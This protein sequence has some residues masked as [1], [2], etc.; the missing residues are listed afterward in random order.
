MSEDFTICDP[1]ENEYVRV[2]FAY[3]DEG[4]SGDYDPTDKDDTPLLRMDVLVNPKHYEGFCEKSFESSW[5]CPDDGSICTSV[6][7]RSDVEHQR[8]ILT[9]AMAI[10]TGA[11][12]GGGR[13]RK[14]MDEISWWF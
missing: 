8:V 13:V 10:L 4:R 2:S 14:V 5:Y 7:A 1:V 6:D 3:C 12:A 9:D 11:V